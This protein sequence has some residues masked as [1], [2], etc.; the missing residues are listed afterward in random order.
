[1][2]LTDQLIA[3]HRELWRR[4]AHHPFVEALAAGTLE[5]E[6]F[7]HY[8]IQDYLFLIDYCRVLALGSAKADTVERQGF[9]AKLTEVTLNTEMEL[10]RSYCERNGISRQELEKASPA[11]TTLGYTRFMLATANQGDLLDIAV[12]LT[13]CFVGYAEI[14]TRLAGLE[15]RPTSGPYHEWIEMYSDPEWVGLCGEFR[16]LTDRLAEEAG[17]TDPSLPRHQRLSAIFAEA[18]R[19]EWMFWQMGWTLEGW[20]EEIA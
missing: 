4:A 8:L 11:P 13:P 9:F 10:H 16:Q 5:E 15:G 2:G 18:V 14:G 7:R 1:M 12:C 17:V 6:K 20:P 3:A 19:W